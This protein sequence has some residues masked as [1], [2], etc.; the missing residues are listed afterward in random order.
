MLNTTRALLAGRNPFTL[1]N[2]P[3]DSNQYGILY[4]AVTAP[5]AFAF[6]PS[7]WVH[8]TMS[9]VF[10]LLSLATLA[11]ACRQRGCRW[12][13]SLGLTALLYV[14]LFTQAASFGL[15][16]RPDSLGLWLMLL[17]V[18]VPWHRGFSSR[19]LAASAGLA[20]LACLTK[21]Y[22]VVGFPFVCAYAFLFVSRRRAV[23]AAVLFAALGTLSVVALE[24]LLPTYA[25][26]VFFSTANFASGPGYAG[27]V[28]AV[29]QLARFAIWYAP[30]GAVGV[31]WAVGRI[32]DHSRSPAL[33]ASRSLG[34]RWRSLPAD[35][36]LFAF[37][38]A[39]AVVYASLGR[40]RGS[41]MA[42]LVHL[43]LPFLLLYV[44]EP[45]A[46]ARPRARRLSQLL[47]L[48]NV[49]LLTGR[50]GRPVDLNASRPAWIR[51]TEIVD[52][53]ERL[54]NNAPLVSLLVERRRI[55]YDSGHS[56]YFRL[57]APRP[58]ILGRILAT[59]TGIADRDRA[60]RE[61]LAR[62]V[63]AKAFDDI[64]V[65]LEG[66]RLVKETLIRNHYREAERLEV[67]LPIA[68]QGWTL[69]VYRPLPEPGTAS[70]TTGKGSDGA[71]EATGR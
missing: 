59:D 14:S 39:S 46:H 2:G 49:L 63:E 62:A 47:I 19:S 18:V 8:R 44:A 43:M 9:A 54:F 22:F 4:H 33:A 36:F 41:Y 66:S 60:Y 11:W 53:S 16:A 20:M 45:L 25:S 42:Y 31:V 57:G 67:T 27:G 71:H 50:Y 61:E 21:T 23:E 70:I 26:T 3:Q 51:L 13:A 28:Y 40:N 68:A 12:S 6:G 15:L 5:L 52:S 35:P 1:E 58:G 32:L 69:V 7:L 37:V 38:G 65:T 48:A 64:V 24:M 30:A 56:Q 17:S 29:R 34:S 55:V 10:V